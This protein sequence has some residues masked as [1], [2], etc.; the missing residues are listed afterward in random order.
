MEVEGIFLN[1]IVVSD[2]KKSIKYYTEVLGLTLDC[3][4]EKYGWAELKAPN[5]ALLGLAQENDYMDM[6]AGSNAVLTLTVKNLEKAKAE[7]SKKGVTMVGDTME[8]P[9]EVKM[10]TIK[11]KDGNTLQIVEKIRK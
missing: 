1:W 3:K 10:Q 5:G 9:D 7:L 8:V 6:K 11:D 4:D 2:L